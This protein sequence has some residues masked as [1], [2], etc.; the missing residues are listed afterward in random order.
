[1]NRIINIF[2]DRGLFKGV[3][4]QRLRTDVEEEGRQTAQVYS[5]EDE[6]K[7]GDLIVTFP[8]GP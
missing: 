8:L 7:V 2:G 3:M 1:M 5:G 4:T 6:P